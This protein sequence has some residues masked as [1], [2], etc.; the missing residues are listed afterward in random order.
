MNAQSCYNNIGSGNDH[1]DISVTLSLST[2]PVCGTVFSLWAITRVHTSQ[3]KWQLRSIPNLSSSSFMTICVLHTYEKQ[4]N[5]T[6]PMICVC[7][8]LTPSYVFMKKN[9]RDMGSY[10]S[11]ICQKPFYWIKSTLLKYHIYECRSSF[12]GG[13]PFW[14]TGQLL[15]YELL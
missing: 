11:W 9:S 6:T 5:E 3:I 8:S 14:F 10:P 4:W 1:D 13:K 12:N 7:L 2:L 15:V